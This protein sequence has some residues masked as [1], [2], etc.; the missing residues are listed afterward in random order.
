M[1]AINSKIMTTISRDQLGLRDEG[2]TT[3]LENKCGLQDNSSGDP[4]EKS[5]GK[6]DP[7]QITEDLHYNI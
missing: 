7:Q 6:E 2:C 4:K 1:A 5:A 3:D